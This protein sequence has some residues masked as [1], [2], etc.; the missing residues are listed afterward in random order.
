MLATA[1]R[2]CPPLGIM[3]VGL[4]ST[5]VGAGDPRPG[6]LRAL[7]PFPGPGW[8]VGVRR[9]GRRSF[10]PKA[11]IGGFPHQ[12]WSYFCDCSRD[13]RLGS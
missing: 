11:G 3:C 12:V 7:T 1:V 2:G 5:G 10:G 4:G 8:P 13:W 6:I 9:A